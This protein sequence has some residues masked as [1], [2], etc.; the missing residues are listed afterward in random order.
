LD[1]SL[2]S[3]GE[4]D[5]GNKKYEL[6]SISPGHYSQRI[7]LARFDATRMNE[8]FAAFPWSKAARASLWKISEGFGSQ[9]ET[10]MKRHGSV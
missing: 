3:I 6:D 2:G 7:G 1:C 8:K 9:K 10:V 4:S 5:E